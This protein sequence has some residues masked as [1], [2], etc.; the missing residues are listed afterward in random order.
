[1]PDKRGKE[2][3]SRRGGIRQVKRAR[4]DEQMELKKF[5]GGRTFAYSLKRAYTKKT[6]S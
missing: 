3:R 1:M 2:N 6:D 4:I 5:Q